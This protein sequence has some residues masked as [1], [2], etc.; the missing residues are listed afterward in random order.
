MATRLHWLVGDEKHGEENP[1]WLRPNQPP[2]AGSVPGNP[3]SLGHTPAPVSR[4]NAEHYRWGVDCDGWH[5]VKDKQL[6]VIEEFMPPGA[7]EIRHHHERSQ[8]FFYILTG[9]VLM[10]IN[11]ENMLIAGRKRRSNPAR[12][13]SPDPQSVLQSSALPGRLAAPKPR[14]PRRPVR[15]AASATQASTAASLVRDCPA[16]GAARP[17]LNSLA[18]PAAP[19]QPP[20]QPAPN[21][22]SQP[23]PLP[24]SIGPLSPPLRQVDRSAGFIS[25]LPV[26]AAGLDSRS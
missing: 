4:D 2:P 1:F 3:S 9:E 25:F 17:R 22:R 26:S 18:F 13:A 24:S 14:R 12:N 16:W 21:G 20:I 23:F 6:S 11:G 5:L 15:D 19:A 10:E 8:Q 7:A